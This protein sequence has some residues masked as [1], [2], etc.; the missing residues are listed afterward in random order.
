MV[1]GNGCWIMAVNFFTLISGS[2]QALL[3]T[4]RLFLQD[5]YTKH[6]GVTVEVE[7]TVGVITIFW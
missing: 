5:I 7:M 2:K 3:P 1:T 6:D 4:R